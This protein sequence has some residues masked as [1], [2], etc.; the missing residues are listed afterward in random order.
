MTKI[1]KCLGLVWNQVIYYNRGTKYATIQVHFSSVNEA[2]KH[3]DK[4]LNTEEEALLPTYMGRRTSRIRTEEVPPEVGVGWVTAALCHDWSDKLNILQINR[5]PAQRSRGQT[6]EVLVLAA[7]GILENMQDRL[8]C[9]E[10]Q[11]LKVAI[12]VRKSQCF[13]CGLKSTCKPKTVEGNEAEK[14]KKTACTGTRTQ[15]EKRSHSWTDNNPTDPKLHPPTDQARRPNK[16]PDQHITCPF[17]IKGLGILCAWK[18]GSDSTSTTLPPTTIEISHS[19]YL[20]DPAMTNNPIPPIP[21]SSSECVMEASAVQQLLR[22]YI[23]IE[24][25]RNRISPTSEKYVNT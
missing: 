22:P 17:N 10:G 24:Y 14:K 13:K 23:N 20:Q 19:Q 11:A 6:I 1:E 5:V 2:R 9:D 12:E 16:Y 15:Q 21:T 7:P 8:F 25:I 4:I 3:S 18:S